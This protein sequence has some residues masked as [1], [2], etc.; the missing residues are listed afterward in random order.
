MIKHLREGRLI[1]LFLVT[2]LIWGLLSGTKTLPAAA[3]SGVNLILNG[4]KVKPT[5]PAYIDNNGRTMLPLRFVMENMNAEVHWIPSEKGILIYRGNTT[6]K[7]WIGSRQAIVDGK[8]IKLDTTPVLKNNTTM[9]PMRFVSQAFGGQV[10]WDGKTRTVS[11]R[12]DTTSTNDT[13]QQ[14]SITGSYVNIRSGPGLGYDIIDVLPRGTVI[15]LLNKTT[16]WY[17]VQLNNGQI[18]WVTSKYSTIVKT[19][20]PLPNNPT[21]NDRS[22]SGERLSNGS[23]L[24]LA[25]IGDKP[26]AVLAGP[27][28]VERQVGIAPAESKLPIL[29]EKGDWWEVEFGNNQRGW[30]STSLATFASYEPKLGEEDDSEDYLKITGIK[31]KILDD[32]IDVIVEA[33]EKFNYKTSRWDNHLIVDIPNA[34][35]DI[36]EGQDTINV[37]HAPVTRVRLG[38]FTT[39][40]VR[41]VFDLSANAILTSVGSNREGVKL[42]I[43]PLTLKNMKIVIDP[44]HGNDP[45]G[46]DPGAIGPSGVKEKDVNLGIS[47]KLYDLLKDA[48]VNVYMTRFGD[49]CPYT[50]SERAFYANDIGAN[51]FISIH[52]NA[53]INSEASGTSTY[54]YAPIGTSLGNQREQR[55]SLARAIQ[56]ALLESAG[57]KDMGIHEANF[58]VLR[59]TAMP[60]VLVETAFLSNP[61][62]EQL[63]T[64]LSFQNKVAEGIFN[65]IKRY[66]S[67]N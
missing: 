40:T 6:L 25:V 43:Q 22:S 28:P 9:V 52:S 65:G 60:S 56:T 61:V 62:E 24:G 14:V 33:E 8:T 3:S 37:N 11:V 42:Q 35:L 49:D 17:K 20:N 54:F 18:G 34:I 51:I 53:S 48:G 38:Q 59:N 45:Y 58:S 7:M 41:I 44:G 2:V 50:L 26:V 29:E 4:Q 39:D 55:L 30:L 12:L 64:Q 21:N 10:D 36:P 1:F 47:L 57:G 13:G 23:P 19:D 5:V 27:S 66:I 32:T 31:V 67:G 63:L 16:G 46:Q 15:K